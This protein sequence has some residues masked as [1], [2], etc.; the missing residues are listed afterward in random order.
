VAV[1]GTEIVVGSFDGEAFVETTR[2][3][4]AST[5]TLG[6]VDGFPAGATLGSGTGELPCTPMRLTPP[7]AQGLPPAVEAARVQIF[8]MA[9]SCDMAGLSELALAHGTAFT[10]GG[11][12]DPLRSWVRSARNGF[13]V[14]GWIVRIFNST[15]AADETETYAWPAVHVTNSDEDW[16]ELSG[17]LSAAEFEQYSQ[18][19]EGGWLGL[20]VG[21]GVDGTW[22]Y[23]IA[24]D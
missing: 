15:P 3:G 8:E 12:T 17:I 10:Y 24:G 1:G 20:R 7:P 21:I 2:L 22:R 9:A 13:D 5:F 18:Y 14:M 19:R 16:D 23:V 4:A 11:E 6:A